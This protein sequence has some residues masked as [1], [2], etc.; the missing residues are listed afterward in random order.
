MS[1][2]LECIACNKTLQK[3]NHNPREVSRKMVKITSRR[4]RTPNWSLEEKQFLL[5]L[6]RERKEVVVT[7]SNN[8]PNHSEEKDVAWNEILYQLAARFGTKFSGFSI[9]KVKTQWQNMK[10]IAREEIILNGASL[11]KC[12]K[13][14]QEVC[15]IL[16]S[17]NAADLKLE[18]ENANVETAMHT[19]VEIKTESI[20]E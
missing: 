2:I 14:S 20:D 6:I 13:Q 3:I 17:Q 10:R 8:G 7:K 16:E 11:L 1:I 19:D 18:S 5:E 12:T 15:N 4:S 9:K